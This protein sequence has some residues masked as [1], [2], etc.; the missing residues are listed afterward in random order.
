MEGLYIDTQ[1]KA[2][3]FLYQLMKNQDIPLLK[4]TFRFFF[5]YYVSENE[6]MVLPHHFSGRKIEGLTVIDELGVSISYEQENPVTK[7]HFTL[8]HELG[9]FF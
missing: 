4:Y 6:I 9:H 7:Q 2:K 8:C 1:Q 3:Q 5:D